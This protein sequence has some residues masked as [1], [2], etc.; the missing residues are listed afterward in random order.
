M[1]NYPD[2]V[3]KATKALS[4]RKLENID[5][6]ALDFGKKPPQARDL[7]EAVLGACMLE[8][9]ALIHVIDILSPDMFYVEGHQHI[10]R[11][12]KD[13]FAKSEPVDIMTVTEQLRLNGKLEAVGGSYYVTELSTKVA[14]GAHVE[15]HARI[16][17][18]KFIQ[19][20]L[21]SIASQVIKDAYDDTVDVFELLDKAETDMFS[22]A[23]EHLKKNT[24]T[25]P[26]ILQQEIKDI[27]ARM[28]KYKEGVS[29]SGVGSGFTKLDRYTSGWQASDLIILAARPGMGKTAFTLALAR[30][31]AIDMNKPIAFFSLEMDAGQIVKR[32][33]SM[34]TELGGEKL[35]EGNLQGYEWTQLTSRIDK[36]RE[37]PIHIDDTPALNIFELRAKCR[38]LKNTHDIQMVIIDYLQLMTTG[39]EGKS[40][41]NREQEISQISRSLKSLAKELKIPVIALSQLSRAVETR[42]GD[43][44]PMLSDLRESGAIEQDA[45]MVIFLYR[46]EYYGITQD[47]EGNDC[48]GI[49]EVIIAK[50]RNGSL[51]TV[52]T[53]F[54]N[55]FAKFANLEEGFSG[56]SNQAG[57]VD[58]ENFQVRGSRMNEMN[59]NL[60]DDNVPF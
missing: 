41:G 16:I 60:D 29:F 25:L 58:P 6:T 31:A 33:I 43:K 21:I 2:S 15:Y 28:E 48:R 42:G 1:S 4:N 38:R 23:E 20:E 19:R 8:P 39:M 3:K 11:A 7:E 51:G 45:D 17:A 30:N 46:P 57:A 24:N 55:Q 53:R 27:S 44:R 35:R 50:H 40:S 37:A 5:L 22:I 54:I 10:Y 52:R 18:Q 56:E 47:E 59:D 49:G 32:L 34:E 12:I 14:S 26:D 36:L 9:K 13:L